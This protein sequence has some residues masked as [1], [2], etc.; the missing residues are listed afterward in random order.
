M[1]CYHQTHKHCVERIRKEG[2]KPGISWQDRPP[3]VYF[4]MLKEE[5]EKVHWGPVMVV[6]EL[7]DNIE[8]IS[9][10]Q[11]ASEDW[12]ITSAASI[13]QTVPPE[14]ILEI[15]DKLT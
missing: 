7:P 13:Q 6:F 9:P 1:L 10:D 2:L 12:D 14:R 11:A 15:Y 4:F 3:S 8:G 5:A